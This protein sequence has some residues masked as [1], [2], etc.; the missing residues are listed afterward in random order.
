MSERRGA[1]LLCDALAAAGARCVFGLPGT[2]NIALFDALRRS[3]LRTIVATHELSAAMMANGHYR[4][5]GRP[6]V[7]VTIP[8]PGF[9]F[10]LTGLA[11]AF[12]DSVAL[13][14]VVGTGL[15]DG[16]A[17]FRLQALD[18]AAAAAPLTKA[19]LRLD[20][21]ADIEA[22]VAQ[23]FAL[24]LAGEPGPVL[25]EVAR[26][27]LDDAAP[28]ARSPVTV[29][30]PAP[31]LDDATLAAIAD[32]VGA[33]RR[34]VLFLGQ[35]CADASDTATALA[36][37]LGAAV[38]TTTSGRGC[39][40]E[41]HPLSLGFEF[42]GVGCATLNALVD[43]ADLVLAIGVKFSHNGS[44]GFAL[45]IARDKLVRID[46]S[47][48]V[49]AAGCYPARIAACADAPTALNQLLAALP[50]ARDGAPRFGEADIA[51]W[52]Q[53]GRAE[54]L[55]AQVEPNVAGAGAAAFFAALERVLPTDAVLLTDSGQHQM[56]ARDHFRVRSPRGLVVPTNL[57]S[58][59]FGIGAAIGASV[60]GR[61]AVALVGDGGFA[62]SGL[63]LLAAVRDGID[64][65][66]I[67][68]V[69][70]AYG[71][72]RAQQLAA[73]G[74]AF[75]TR[76]ARFELDAFAA[77]IGAAY[78]R[79]DA[80]AEATL[81]KALA[82]RGVVVVE[83]PLHDSAGMHW[84]RAKGIARGWLGPGLRRHLHR[85]RSTP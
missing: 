32:A 52:R 37:R 47:P 70:H 9:T 30:A 41:D 23:A 16:D 53:R 42:G 69:D 81:R 59:G 38:V 68:F 60:A 14:H 79:V 46:A 64:V 33:A 49:L 82:T 22:V 3:P 2:Q 56:L 63:E 13:V 65:I 66:V 84:M 35:G 57:Q 85:N 61:R 1:D 27:V 11:E 26:H 10:A 25:L 5:T 50:A 62:M 54:T 44:R 28:A 24:A 80:D 19:R 74:H 40:A 4:A 43:D 39:V 76:L 36:G 73:S 20:D 18:Q 29:A 21:A 45:R 71:M 77:S 34:C 17:P 67:V 51:Q 15:R 78:L 58:M 48:A 8:G 12:L 72:I 75:G 6:G 55:A 83:V 31:R 7:L